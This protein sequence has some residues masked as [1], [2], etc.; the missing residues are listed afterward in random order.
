MKASRE[1]DNLRDFQ[2]TIG[3]YFLSYESPKIIGLEGVLITLNV[4]VLLYLAN[5]TSSGSISCVTSPEDK[6]QPSIASTCTGV[7][8]LTRGILCRFVNSS[9]TKQAKAPKSNK[10]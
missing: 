10:A 4:I 7:A 5:E 8:F 3:L 9:S 1:N 6:A 2:S